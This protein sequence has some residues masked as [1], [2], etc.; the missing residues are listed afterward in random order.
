MAARRKHVLDIRE[1]LRR[2]RMGEHERRIALDTGVSRNTVAKYR[3]WARDAGFLDA[4]ELPDAAA[5][6][7]RIESERPPDVASRASAC[8]PHREVIATQRREGVEIKA[9]LGLLRER[10]Y[11]G[12]YSV[13]RRYVRRNEA[14]MPETFIRVETEPGEESQ[15]D[16]GYRGEIIDVETGLLRKAWTFVMTLSNSRHQFARTVFN[17]TVETWCDL[18][19]RAF[20]WFGGAPR[21]VVLDNLKAAIVKA[22]LH[23]AEAQR[24]YRECAEHYG[25]LISPCRPATPEHKGKVESGVHYVARNALAG[26]AFPN[27]AEENAYLERWVMEVAG[28]RDHGTT[29]ERPLDRFEIER[30]ALLP[31]PPSRYEVAVWKQVK[32]HPDC[33]IV[34]D[35]SY[36]SAPH[37][38]V[39]QRL[40]VRATLWRVEI[41]REY[42]RIFSHTRATRK[43]QR[44]TFRDHMPPEK[45]QG[46]LPAPSWVRAQAQTVGPSTAEVIE[47]LLGERPLDRLR[48]AQSILRMREQVGNGRLEAACR[49]A[50]AFDSVKYQS[51]KKILH[52][53]L[54]EKPFDDP[55]AGPA[56]L[57]KTSIF[58]RPVAEL[59]PHNPQNQKGEPPWKA[60]LTYSPN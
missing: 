45:L 51:I 60:P 48:G 12:S 42:E 18:H 55:S 44:I 39:G 43:G 28:V 5:I 32:L 41:F 52:A 16:F 37:R 31:L 1:L 34:F 27:L 56:P 26:R 8:E 14:K 33:H 59:F 17:Q 4:T 53:R 25:F 58:A 3:K 50:L 2:I 21:R 49:R 9:L 30:K 29:H 38:L 23:D 13:L 36:Y 7:A 57:P 24:S 54:D 46:L 20:E 11:G 22:V 19:R 15:V 47:R 6:E 35:Y 10:G 40:W